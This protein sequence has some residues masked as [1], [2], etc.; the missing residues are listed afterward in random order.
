MPKLASRTLPSA[1]WKAI[2]TEECDSEVDFVI[3]GIY[4]SVSK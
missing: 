1:K 3:L 4:I 2:L